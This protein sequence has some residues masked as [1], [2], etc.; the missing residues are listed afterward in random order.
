MRKQDFTDYTDVMVVEEYEKAVESLEYIYKE[1]VYQRDL[2][3][4]VK[5]FMY[6]LLQALEDCNKPF[7]I[8]G[9]KHYCQRVLYK[10]R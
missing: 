9:W 10:E 8:E 3:N 4:A 1:C 5:M 2:N 6:S 7:D